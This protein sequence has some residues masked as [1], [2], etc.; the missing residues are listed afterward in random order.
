MLHDLKTK[1]L[2]AET[3]NSIQTRLPRDITALSGSCKVCGQKVLGQTDMVPLRCSIFAPG[4]Q[5]TRQFE[6]E[7]HGT[8][9]R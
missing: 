2:I 6:I 7:Q 3:K 8:G 4:V 9:T 1:M 5:R